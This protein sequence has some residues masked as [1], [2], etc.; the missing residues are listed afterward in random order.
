[1]L[2]RGGGHIEGHPARP[3]VVAPPNAAASHEAG[4]PTPVRDGGHTEGRPARP[5]VAAPAT[6]SAAAAAFGG[7]LY[8][9]A[10]RS[11]IR[12]SWRHL[13]RWSRRWRTCD[14]SACVLDNLEKVCV[15]LANLLAIVR[16]SD[17]ATV[18]SGSAVCTRT[19]W[20]RKD[21]VDLAC[22]QL[23]SVDLC[24]VRT[25]WAVCFSSHPSEYALSMKSFA[26]HCFH[27]GCTKPY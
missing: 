22:G 24:A 25:A 1:M 21:G 18:R 7:V 27:C 3:T 4:P 26:E 6:A 16:S 17:G 23:L 5:T 10:E 2:V 19:A 13:M 8:P 12:D 15:G 11:Q 14:D 20:S 9:P